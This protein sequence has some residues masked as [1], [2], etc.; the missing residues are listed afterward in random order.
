MESIHDVVGLMVARMESDPIEFIGPTWRWVGP[1]GAVKE[2]GNEEEKAAINA[3][4]RK[5]RLDAAHEDALDELLNGPEN[6]RETTAGSATNPLAQQRTS[7]HA[8]LQNQQAVMQ[9]MHS[10]LGSG[11]SYQQPLNGYQGGKI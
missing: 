3:G 8:P 1:M 5:V 6:R 7:Q 9:G 11:S 10:P 2:F 4:L